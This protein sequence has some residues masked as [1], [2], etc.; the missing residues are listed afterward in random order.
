MKVIYNLICAKCGE[1][2]DTEEYIELC[3]K[4]QGKSFIDKFK[5]KKDE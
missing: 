3:V 5:G 2:F 4:C 1:K